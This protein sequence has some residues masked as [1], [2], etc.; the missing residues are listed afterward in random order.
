MIAQRING[1]LRLMPL[2]AVYLL[3]A[4]PFAWL[5][6]QAVTGRLGVDPTKAIEW[7]LGL[8]GLQFLLGGLCITPLRWLTGVNL[9]RFRRAVGLLA[10]AYVALHL[11]TWLLLDIQLRWGEI[12]A[13]LT[14]RPYIMIGMVG[15]AAMVPLAVTSNNLSIRRMGAAAWQQLH[16]LTY[17]AA[18]A[19]G[20]HYMVLVKA[21]PLEPMLYLGGVVSLLAW[22]AVRGGRRL[23]ARTA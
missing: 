22:R 20:L 17:L 5:V 12:G 11:L 8:T 3:G 10:F 21:W 6:V 4:L 13:D 7:S 15:F 16:K 1:A 2:W 23:A 19:G 14:K 9:I 18:L